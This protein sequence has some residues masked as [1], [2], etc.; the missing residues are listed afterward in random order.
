MGSD[1]TNAIGQK[2]DALLEQGRESRESQIRLDLKVD[3]LHVQLFGA[4]EDGFSAG[5]LPQIKSRIQ[6]VDD[7]VTEDI[8]NLGKRM[9]DIEATHA[10]EAGEA[11]IVRPFLKW[12]ASG[13]FV[14]L[15]QFLTSLLNRK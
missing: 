14:I 11:G 9:T 5:H 2:L 7:R 13:I 15:V 4:S 3:Q 10:K 1:E 8:T 12:T 6:S